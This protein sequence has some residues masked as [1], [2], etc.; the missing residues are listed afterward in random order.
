MAKIKSVKI[1]KIVKRVFAWAVITEMGIGIYEF[2][3]TWD[4]KMADEKIQKSERVFAVYP[5]KK[6]AMADAKYRGGSF[7]KKII[8]S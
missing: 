6:Q 3:Y 4:R 8:L 2:C 5:T 7:V 1:K